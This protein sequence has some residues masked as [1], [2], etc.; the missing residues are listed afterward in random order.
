[1]AFQEA[2]RHKSIYDKKAGAIELQPGDC[3]L[4]KMDAFQGPEEKLKNQWSDDLWKV[5]R[6]IVDDVPTYIACSMK[7]GKTTVLHQVRLLFWL[8]NYTQDSLKVNVLRLE[9][10][11]L[12]S[13]MLEPSPVKEEE[14]RPPFEFT[15]GLDLAK[16]GHSLDIPV[17]MMDIEAQG[18]PAGTS[19]NKTSLTWCYHQICMTLSSHL[20]SWCLHAPPVQ[21]RD[22][23]QGM[24]TTA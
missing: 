4:V 22:K 12:P 9:D 10:D 5:V 14:G 11:M 6:W 21:G 8:A 7:T 15:Y 3:V 24:M 18:M 17:S 1:M 2:H 23:W 16:L 20:D 19:Q 13:T